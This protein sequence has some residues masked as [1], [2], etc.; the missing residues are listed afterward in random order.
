LLAHARTAAL[1]P[2]DF[3]QFGHSIYLPLAAI[4]TFTIAW[5]L[6]IAHRRDPFLHGRYMVGTVF[7][8]FDPISARLLFFYSGLPPTKISTP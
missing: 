6:A 4:F 2:A 5:A 3:A 8:L 7:S 1:N